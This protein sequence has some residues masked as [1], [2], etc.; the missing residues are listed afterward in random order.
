MLLSVSVFFFVGGSF[1]ILPFVAV[2]LL[3]TLRR[4]L[5]NI[6]CKSLVFDELKTI[7]EEISEVIANKAIELW[8]QYGSPLVIGDTHKEKI[9][10]DNL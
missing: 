3:T 9:N 6:T 2:I 10:L 4:N 8:Q 1:K 7:T 5:L